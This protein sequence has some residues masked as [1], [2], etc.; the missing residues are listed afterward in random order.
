[1]SVIF[2]NFSY[3]TPHIPHIF[4]T[5]EYHP[6][7]ECG[8]GQK[9]GLP[10]ESQA[11]AVGNTKTRPAFRTEIQATLPQVTS[12]L[13]I[14]HFCDFFFAMRA[15]RRYVFFFFESDHRYLLW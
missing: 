5:Y 14:P 8:Q 11:L 10:A 7:G 3:R 1:M 6:F 2:H 4:S 12:E 9:F 15:D 13:P